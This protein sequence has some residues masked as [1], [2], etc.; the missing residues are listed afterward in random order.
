MNKDLDQSAELHKLFTDVLTTA[1]GLEETFASALMVA[2]THELSRRM[3]QTE[4]WIP[5][6]PLRTLR[7]EC[8]RE[9]L[10]AG[11]SPAEVAKRYAITTRTV[12]RAITG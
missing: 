4:L 2:F 12:Y 5:S 11:D 3:G 6:N 1:T 9:D 7:D 8:I 10:K